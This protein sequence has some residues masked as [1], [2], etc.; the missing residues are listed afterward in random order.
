MMLCRIEATPTCQNTS[1]RQKC[2]MN[3]RAAFISNSKSSMLMYPRNRAFDEP[4][5]LAKSGGSLHTSLR[6]FGFD[7]ARAKLRAVRTRMISL[8]ALYNFWSLTR[9][10]A[11][12]TDWRYRIDQ[13]NQLRAIV[14]I[15]T[16]DHGDQRGTFS[17]RDHMVF[18]AF[19]GPVRGVWADF[20]P[21][22]TARTEELSTSA[23]LQSILSAACSFARRISWIFC[24]TPAFCQ[25]AK[26]RQQLMPEP[27]PIS[28]GNICQGMPV[29]RTN[30]IPASARRCSIGFRPGYFRRR[31]LGGGNT[32][33]M[34]SHRPS[35]TSAVAMLSP[36]L[37]AA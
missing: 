22:K 9:S 13:V 24:Q 30:I 35:S 25:A 4:S 19:L 14:N 7:A 23:R 12:S 2:L 36:A 26:Y 28:C 6:Q 37:R 32:G 10:S 3:V 1:E 34:T 29:R 15:G 8:V 18:R 11:F 31:F 21:P 33:S 17:L 5:C 16:R 20:K 27:Q